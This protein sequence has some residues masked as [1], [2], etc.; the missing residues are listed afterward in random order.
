[1]HRKSHRPASY[2]ASA[3]QLSNNDRVAQAKQKTCN[4]QALLFS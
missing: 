4:D 1:M 2:D 3:L